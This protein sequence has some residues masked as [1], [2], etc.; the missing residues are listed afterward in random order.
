MEAR[1]PQCATATTAEAIRNRP[2]ILWQTIP[3]FLPL[4]SSSVSLASF[5]TPHRFVFSCSLSILSGPRGLVPILIPVANILFFSHSIP[6]YALLLSCI[7]VLV[8]FSFSLS[9]YFFSPDFFFFSLIF[10]HFQGLDLQHTSQVV[11]TS[12][13]EFYARASLI[14]IL[15]LILDSNYSL[16]ML[17]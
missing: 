9:Y 2:M 14:L 12:F 4:R 1:Y 11:N 13:G 16:D 8:Q 17:G 5:S 10:T 6:V 3:S 15:I 7:S